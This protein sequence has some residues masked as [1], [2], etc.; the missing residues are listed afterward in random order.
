MASSTQKTTTPVQRVFFTD[1][2]DALPLPQLVSH[3][4]DSWRD[5]VETGLGEIFAELNPIE[6]YTGQKLEL[7]FKDYKFDEPKETETYTK[8]NN[9]TF[10]APLNV[11]VELTNKVT[12]EVKEQEIYMGDYPW[13]TNR[14]TF[15]VNGTERVVVSQLIRSAGVFFTAEQQAGRGLYGAKLIPGR[16]AWLEFETAANGAIYVKIDRRRKLPVTTLLRA[17]GYGKISDIRQAFQD[18]DTGDVS[19]IEATLEK[20]TT[21]GPNEAL[22]EVYRKL[23]PGDLATVDNARQM[24]ERMFF[25]FKRFDYS[26]VGRYKLNKRLG[27]DLPNT[28][29]YRVFQLSDLIA[30]IREIIRLNNTQEPGD[31]IDALDNRRVKL[32]GELV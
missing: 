11:T 28:A 10:E 32:V 15:V 17:L 21:H 14:A 27:L 2:D 22:I 6:D 30:I 1:Q 12:G 16:G 7:R 25:D 18:I 3:Q 9:M 5:F 8:E 29:D 31:D 24:I 13:M 26:R 4:F 20:D 23:R 19:Y